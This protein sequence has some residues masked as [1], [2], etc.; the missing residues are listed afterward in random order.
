MFRRLALV[1][2]V[3]AAFVA[4]R[5]S[6]IVAPVA[7]APDTTALRP[8]VFGEGVFST[9]LYDF[10]VTFTPKG[11]TA[12]FSRATPGF[13]Y[14][15]IVWSRYDGRR[16]SPPE[17]APFSGRWSDADAHLSPDGSKLF[18]ISN[19]P[20]DGGTTPKPDYDIWYVDRTPTGWS[21]PKHLPSPIATAAV[22]WCPSIARD[23]SL[24]FGA[25]RPGG[26]GG[27]DI[28]VSRLVNGVYGQPENLGDSV[29]STGGEI[30]PW[31]APDESFLVFSGAGRAEAVGQLDLYIS[32]R[33]NGV[34]SKATLLGNGINSGGADFNPSVSPDG[35]WFYFTSTRGS[36]D[37]PPAAPLSYREMHRRLAGRGNG[38]GDIY[39]IRIEALGIGH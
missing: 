14:F 12:F 37:E 15:T 10:F 18:F 20:I 17:M 13:S 33:R 21:E 4:T 24:Y 22:E 11:D 34:W 2:V 3:L 6:G 32:V 19:R 9:E 25:V 26:K 8:E 38:L 27:N 36:F 31:I 1:A 7:A 16:W 23:G 30:E 39:R 35:R 5:A 29:N 28:Y